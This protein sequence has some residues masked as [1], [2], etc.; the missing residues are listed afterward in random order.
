MYGRVRLPKLLVPFQGLNQNGM[1]RVNHGMMRAMLRGIVLTAML[2]CT[3]LGAGTEVYLRSGGPGGVEITGC[4]GSG[5]LT[6]TTRNAHGFQAG[7]LIGLENVLGLTG[8]DGIRQ[9]S[10]T[11]SAT[12][13]TVDRGADGQPFSVT[14]TWQK[15]GGLQWAGKVAPFQL[16][17][18]PRGILD[19]AG[20]RLTRALRCAVDDGCLERI[21]VAGGTATATLPGGTRLKTGDRF[22]VW[23]ADEVRLNGV[24]TVSATTDTSI[25]FAVNAPDGDYANALLTVS[26]YAWA[27]NP[28]WDRMVIAAGG[29][30]GQFEQYNANVSF[31]KYLT[32]ALVWFTDRTSPR[33]ATHLAMARRAITHV[34]DSVFGSTACDETGNYCNGRGPAVDYGRG[35]V[36]HA[37]A[38]YSLLAAAG[39]IEPELKRTFLD[40]IFND[41]A[42][43]CRI[44]ETAPGAG[45]VTVTGR[46]VRGTG[47]RFA[48]DLAPGDTLWL[49]GIGNDEINLYRVAAIASDTELTLSDVKTYT[50]PYKVTKAWAPGDCG[51]LFVLK[52][53]PSSILT[54]PSVHATTGGMIGD[55]GGTS[56]YHNLPLTSVWS[57][58]LTALPLADE[59]PRAQRLLEGAWLYGYDHLLAYAMNSWTGFTQAGGTYHW[60]RSPWMAADTV[61]ALWGGVEGYPDLRGS[62]Y[63]RNTLAV[64]VYS[65]VP[66]G[67]PRSDDA[68]FVQFGEGSVQ[69]SPYLVSFHAKMMKLF[70]GTPEAAIFTWWLKNRYGYTSDAIAWNQGQGAMNFYLGVNPN[71]P[72]LDNTTLPTQRLFNQTDYPR[73]AELGMLFCNNSEMKYALAL[74]RTGWTDPND[75]LVQ[76]YS[77]TYQEDHFEN[78]A[79]DYRIIKGPGGAQPCLLGGDSSQ[80]ATAFYSGLSRNNLIEVGPATFYA[81]KTAGLTGL[82]PIAD[83]AR[84][85]GDRVSGDAGNRYVYALADTTGVFAPAAGVA[86]AWRHFA[87]FKK[88]GADEYLVVF[89]DIAMARPS[90]I[91]GFTHYAQNGQAGEGS[92][93]CEGGC[94]PAIASRRVI[95]RSATNALVTQ[96]Y[97]AHPSQRLRL[98]TDRADGTYPGGNGYT[99]RTTYCAA[100]NSNDEAA[101]A[102]DASGMEALIVHRIVAGNG[103]TALTSRLLALPDEWAGVETPDAVALFARHGAT[104]AYV[105][106][107]RTQHSG[108]ARYLVAGLAPGVY[109]VFRDGTPLLTGVQVAAADHS[110]YFESEAGP[111][112]IKPSEGEAA[113]LTSAATAGPATLPQARQPQAI[114]SVTV[115][116]AVDGDGAAVRLVTV[117]ETALAEHGADTLQ[118]DWGATPDEGMTA[119]G[120]GW[121]SESVECAGG[122]TF[123]FGAAPNSVIYLRKIYRLGEMV[124]ETQAARPLLVP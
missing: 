116:E 22:G 26:E 94:G 99:F 37:T 90:A 39:Q 36:I 118:V 58:V 108:T 46:S 12:S 107:F 113:A 47:T 60:Y 86:R 16:R 24:F 76:L 53:H 21:Q 67:G 49:P 114:E 100:A 35:R 81:R 103:D 54:H 27:G 101:C 30:A 18:H 91:R 4:T 11:P 93:T 55:G 19:G 121:S 80:C 59:D 115:E 87:H 23:N 84:W 110:L 10:Q 45:T 109:D 66:F 2:A 48:A 70:E 5:P 33:A 31:E 1:I 6:C 111:I 79:G 25:T 20:G 9:V 71:D 123:T 40:K 122:C 8:A 13:F 88:P 64:D 17:A 98:F 75:T 14:G 104:P 96:Y 85:A 34:E 65:L 78:Q 56:F 74:S 7:D 119:G 32:A 3:V 51:V 102:S 61:Y 112:Y 89:D 15:G 50:G 77:G 62:F 69:A 57:Y 97:S 124:I 68:Y 63:L 43:G 41:K 72:G 38:V 105:P 73:C 28:A 95:S 117:T 52:H 44:P 106:E 92:T 29:F 82:T 83:F 42:D 120:P